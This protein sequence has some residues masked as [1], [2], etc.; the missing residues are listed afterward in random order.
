MLLDFSATWCS[1]C[2]D[3]HQEGAFKEPY[4]NYGPDGTDELMV[5]FVESDEETN[6]ACLYGEADCNSSTYGDWVTG[7]PYPF[8][9]DH[10]I[11]DIYNITGYPT[12][13]YICTNLLMNEL[14]YDDT[15]VETIYNLISSCEVATGA[16]NGSQSKSVS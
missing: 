12:L 4:E 7:K 16:N 9:D 1:P 15:S 3:F 8:F 11:A 6:T 10:L 13:A 5:F 14:D 2:W